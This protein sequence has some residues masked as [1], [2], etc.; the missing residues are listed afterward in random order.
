LRGTSVP[1]SLFLYDK[2]KLFK[3]IFL[4]IIMEQGDTSRT[5][6]PALVKVISVL[7]YVGAGVIFLLSLGLLL[8]AGSIAA[9]FPV[10]SALSLWSVVIAI[11]FIGVSVLFFFL[12][13]G[14]WKGKNWAR[15]VVII[16][17]LLGITLAV[18]I[19]LIL[20]SLNSLADNFVNVIFNGFVAGY[21]LFSKKV[22][23]AFS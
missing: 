9:L 16:F 8:S 6:V 14:L 22:K 4:S 20:G 5:N 10:L 19:P 12:G 3:D 7:Y 13:K 15:V 18:V 1:L 11:S 2:R 23:E 17:S 21:F